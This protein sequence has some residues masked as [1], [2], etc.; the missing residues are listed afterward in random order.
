MKNML[1]K[2]FVTSLV[3]AGVLSFLFILMASNKNGIKSFDMYLGTVW[4][5]IL[6]FIVVLSLTHIFKKIG[7]K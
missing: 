5:F 2:S 6:S 1:K 3:F 7:N 4:V